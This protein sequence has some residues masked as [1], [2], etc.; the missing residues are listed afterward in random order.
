MESKEIFDE[1]IRLWGQKSQIIFALEEMSELSKELC[2]YLREMENIEEKTPEQKAE[3]IA[4]IQEETADVLITVS[5]IANM[6]DVRQVKKIKDGKFS[7][8]EKRI[9]KRKEQVFD[10]EK[11]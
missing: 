6:F 8:L 1:C 4:R 9:A 5:Q 10:R 2:K 11:Q 3:T 7:R